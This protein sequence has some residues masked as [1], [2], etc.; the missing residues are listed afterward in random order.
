[1]A[2]CMDL[3]IALRRRE[4]GRYGIELRFTPAEGEADLRFEA[5]AAP[6]PWDLK[7]ILP[8]W[9][10]PPAYGRA[11][12]DDFLF[13]DPEVRS[14]FCS[15]YRT[16]ESQGTD[17]RVRLFI[18]PDA[19]ELQA[20]RWETLI[21]PATGTPLCTSNRV[22][23]SRY[24]SS[25]DWRPVRLRRRSELSALVVVANPQGLERYQLAKVD[26]E[27]EWERAR[28][29]LGNIPT[30]GLPTGV[31]PTLNAIVA[32]LRQGCDILYLI[33]HGQLKDDE[34]WL[35]LADASNQVIRTRGADL[36]TRIRE[37]SECPRLL[38]LA[39]CQGAGTG[40]EIGERILPTTAGG[41]TTGDLLPDRQAK[42]PL[43]GSRSA[44]S[45][46]GPR[47][48]E[49]GVPAV[50]AMQGNIRIATV[51]RLIPAL[52]A[53][54]D[55]PAYSGE[56]DRALAV[57]RGDLRDC[58]DWWAPTLF[59]RLKNGRIWYLPGFA[60]GRPE[61]EQWRSIC[62]FVR[63]GQVV[64]IVG[65]DIAE[66]IY[67]RLQ[68]LACD[69]AQVNG[70]PLSQQD[71]NDLA[72]VAQFISASASVEDARNQ[73]LGALRQGLEHKAEAV[74]GGNRPQGLT[75]SALLAKL[76]PE[77]LRN[78]R[79]PLRVLADLNAR[80]YVSASSN[81]TLEAVLRTLGREPIALVSHWRDERKGQEPFYPDTDPAH[82][83]LH[84]IF[85]DL[86]EKDTW[87]LTRGRLLR[88]PDPHLPLSRPDAAGDQQGAYWKQPAVPGLSPR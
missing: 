19:G 4:E 24:L 86:R 58:P 3:E 33:C 61:F 56:I 35:F 13:A 27:L 31:P 17:L 26:A 78:P 60:G 52:F 1:V 8:L 48:A 45:A 12:A 28:Q 7:Q 81:P 82:P 40:G 73:V 65:P 72:K 30:R 39:S 49:A 36:V 80:V 29:G 43:T 47:L 66:H 46:L 57:A 37:L 85:G 50:I 32:E 5:G 63:K 68:D 62:N 74:L 9:D 83:Y 23:F 22:R 59:M 34:P 53:A 20:L 18:G 6:R 71:R 64:P 15:A 10:D 88:L 87:V 11:L 38:V 42:L 41:P 70:F 67:G 25:L 75:P 14:S 21:N 76:L 69:L 54:L 16:T 79:E 44:L 2:D 84:Y 77:L 51:E 55:E